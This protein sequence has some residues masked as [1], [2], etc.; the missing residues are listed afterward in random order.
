MSMYLRQKFLRALLECG[1]LSLISI[2]LS[3]AEIEQEMGADRRAAGLEEVVVTARRR[4]ENSQAVP[5]SITTLS[6]S[7]L[8]EK[9]IAGIADL[10]HF[11]PSMGLFGTR[12]QMFVSIRGQGGGGLS[13]NQAVILYLNEVPMPG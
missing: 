1:F 11:V 12:D 7:A 13:P 6:Q 4:E 2:Q 5:I 10:Q 8:Q 9:S 3:A